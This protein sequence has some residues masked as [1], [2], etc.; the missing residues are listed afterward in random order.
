MKLTDISPAIALSPLDGRYH[1]QTAELTE[2]MSEPAL[3]RERLHVE[4]EWMILLANG[5]GDGP[6]VGGVKPF[7]DAEIAYLRAIPENFGAEGIAQMAA[8]EAITHHDVKAVEYYIDDQLDKAPESLGADTQL[9]HIKQLVHFACTSEDINNLSYALCIKQAVENV[10]TPAAEKIVDHLAEK[11]EAFKDKA[12]LS[13]THG[14]PATPT[15]LGKEL[16][17]YVYRLRRQMRKIADQEYLGKIN[18]ATGTFGA[19]LAAYPDVDWVAVSR[20]FVTNRM[21]LTWNPLTTQIE[22]HDWQAELY[23]TI[24]HVNRILH[25]LCVDVWMYISRGVFAQVPVKGA[26]GS[27]TMPH[28]VNPIRFENAEANFEIS[29]SLLETLAAT[30]VESRWQRDLTD[31]TTQ[32]NVGVGLGYSLLALNNLLGGLNS[33]HPNDIVIERELDENWE[34]LGEPIQTAMRA[35]ALEGREGMD[36]PYEK[37]KELMRGHSISKQDVESFIATLDF[38]EETAKRLSSL[39]PATYTGIADKLVDFD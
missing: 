3:N 33:I 35:A 36:K 22:S 19:H 20:E 24:S 28:K 5:M 6:I 8:H 31:S 12:M 23:S 15:T 30:L 7:T 34:V 14:Q 38:D 16:A 17:V 4:V 2:Y 25:N 29:C 27:S 11:A 18:G 21:G 37:V 39:T 10:W 13:L 1:K 32:R 9:P 26:T